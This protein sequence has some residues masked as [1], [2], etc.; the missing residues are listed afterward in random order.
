MTTTAG[1]AALFGVLAPLMVIAALGL[2]FAKRAVHAAMCV[3]FVMISLAILYV[4][5]EAPFLGIVQVVVYTGAVM[6]LFLF[7]LMLVGVDAADSLTE[8]IR[9][10][11]W[12]GVLFGA[13]LLVVLL[14]VL[15]RTDLPPA[16]GLD[17]ANAQTNP[18][19]LA[20]I[21]FGDY[22]IGMEVIGVLLVT[23]A[24]AG[25][26]LT[27]RRRLG[28]RRSQRTM[29]AE[30]VAGLPDGQVLTPLPAPGVY[31]QNNAMD[32]PALG[33]D[34]QPLEHSV[35]RVLR[36]RGQQRTAADVLAAEE[37]LR[38]RLGLP[39]VATAEPAVPP[40]IEPGVR[41]GGGVV[42]TGSTTGGGSTTGVDD[43]EVRG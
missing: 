2:L 20:A 41:D 9:G 14:T 25:L 15:A 18:T 5:N 1:E 36:I 22:V 10:Q 35:P 37:T 23:A 8:T 34:G 27:H 39:A 21:L 43:E 6:M 31:A 26:V 32:T 40:V 12:I 38:A 11:R 33:P 29:A 16:I 4:A 13:G 7:V 30:R 24:L 28:P 17:L 19:G 42:S 3:V